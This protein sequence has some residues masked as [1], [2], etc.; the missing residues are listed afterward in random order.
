[1]VAKIYILFQEKKKGK[2]KKKE[3]NNF[4]VNKA[5]YTSLGGIDSLTS[6]LPATGLGGNQLV[7]NGTIWRDEFSW[8]Q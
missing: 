6:L 7:N 5:S 2:K 8:S 3:N 4:N 1:M